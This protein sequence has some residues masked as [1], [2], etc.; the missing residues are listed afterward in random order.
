[1]KYVLVQ[2]SSGNIKSSILTENYVRDKSMLYDYTKE[3]II[4][5]VTVQRGDVSTVKNKGKLGRIACVSDDRKLLEEHQNLLLVEESEFLIED[6]VGSMSLSRSKRPRLDNGVDGQDESVPGLKRKVSKLVEELSVEKAKGQELQ[7]LNQTLQKSLPQ[8]LRNAMQSSKVITQ[9]QTCPNCKE[10]YGNTEADTPTIESEPTTQ[11]EPS[12][13][14][15]MN[16]LPTILSITSEAITQY[17]SPLNTPVSRTISHTSMSMV[18]SPS[19]VSVHSNAGSPPSTPDAD[20]AMTLPGMSTSEAD[21][22]LPK[23]SSAESLKIVPFC[24]SPEDNNNLL[25]PRP[26]TSTSLTRPIP[27]E[28]TYASTY[29]KMTLALLCH[30]FDNEVLKVSSVTGMCSPGRVKRQALDKDIVQYIIGKHCFDLS[31]TF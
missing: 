29:R 5:F 20:L 18:A 6:D 24:N 2:W 27:L 19:I 17:T 30:L 26:E 23:I 8:L 16:T 11:D 7:K 12:T 3:G 14:D 4:S 25:S 9:L 28:V 22:I 21:S 1:M 15:P 13:T 31:L 10:S